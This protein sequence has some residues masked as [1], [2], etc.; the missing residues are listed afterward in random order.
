MN[1]NIAEIRVETN[2]VFGFCFALFLNLEGI[3]AKGFGISIQSGVLNQLYAP[4]FF[5]I[6]GFSSILLYKK[7]IEKGTNRVSVL[8]LATVL[9]SILILLTSIKWFDATKAVRDLTYIWLVYLIFQVFTWKNISAKYTD[10]KF[11]SSLTIFFLVIFPLSYFIFESGEIE[12]FS[13]WVLSKPQFANMVF[14]TGLIFLNS[15]FRKSQKHIVSLLCII[16]IVASGTRT[17][18]II[19][20]AYYLYYFLVFKSENILKRISVAF[21]TLLF[22]SIIVIWIFLPELNQ[23]LDMAGTLRAFSFEDIESGSIFSRLF[24]YSTVLESLSSENLFGGFGAGASERLLGLLTHFDFLRF[25]YDYTLLF[26]IVF[27]GILYHIYYYNRI[28]KTVLH[29]YIDGALFTI[30]IFTLM[31]HNVFQSFTMVA[32]IMLYLIAGVKNSNNELSSRVYRISIIASPSL[33][34]SL[35]DS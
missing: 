7:R 27:M 1:F 30:I 14:L 31:G 21:F 8:F 23:L 12:R 17:T 18:L 19:F 32:M 11:I 28:Y 16:L 34:K 26:S 15:G 13:G 22:F 24:W 3:I 4:L 2:T 25:W 6:F 35:Q 29:K 9:L 20:L 5:I 33:S 10:K